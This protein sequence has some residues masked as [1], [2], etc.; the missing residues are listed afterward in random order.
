MIFVAKS[1]AVGDSK[2]E[3]VSLCA[4]DWVMLFHLLTLQQESDKYPVK[5][6]N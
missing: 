3:T 4:A 1:V 6:F 5:S 2:K